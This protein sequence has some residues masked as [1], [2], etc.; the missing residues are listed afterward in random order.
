MTDRQDP[1]DSPFGPPLKLLLSKFRVGFVAVMFVAGASIM[2]GRLIHLQIFHTDFLQAQGNARTI[3]IVDIPTYRGH[4]LDRRGEPLAVSTPK[5]SVWIDPRFFHP[6]SVQFAQLM[7][8]LELEISPTQ[9]KIRESKSKY[10]VYLKRDVSPAVVK[11][12]LELNLEGL[13][14][15][16]EFRRYYPAGPDLAQVIGFTDIDDNGLSGIE[17]GFN[18]WLKATHGKKRV[19]EDPTGK[20]VQDLEDVVVAKAGRNLKLSIDLRIQ[21]L[22]LREL[23]QAVET[24]KAKSATLVMIDVESGEILTMITA[25][26]YNP[27]NRVERTGPNMRNRALTDQFEPGSTMKPFTIL[28]GLESGHF[29]PET[30]VNTDPG[31]YFIGEHKVRD[32]RNNGLITLTEILLR[33]SNVG[34]SRVAL[35]IPPVTFLESLKRFGVGQSLQLGFPGESTGRFND[36]PKVDTFSRATMSFG[37]GLAVTPVH[38][39]WAYATLGALGVKRPLSLLK[40]EGP[41]PGV[42]IAATDY[43]RQLL[44]MLALVPERGT[45]KRA[46]IP[47][48]RTAGKTGTIRISEGGRGYSENRHMGL[49][50]GITPVAHP[51]LATVVVV[52]EA[53]GNNYYGGLSAAPIYARVVGGALHLL[54]IPPDNLLRAE[55]AQ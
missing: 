34:V 54:N 29:N 10:F 20:W 19:I 16:R 48:Y 6:S 5:D 13:H 3:R 27:N 47:G 1:E 39:T 31:F 15:Q 32:L 55:E 45:A 43:S 52:E 40:V 36:N 11:S 37:Y 4:I 41:V 42:Q 44:D 38:L 30:L 22:A 26:S 46:Q 23:S 9:K 18:D 21:S 33:S 35:T 53:Q 49:F 14:L 51:R 28:M 24:L 2:L 50:A 7:E 8:L 12:I 17:L 25:P